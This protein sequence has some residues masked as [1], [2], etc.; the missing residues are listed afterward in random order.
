[1]RK[2]FL[3]LM[4]MALL[5]LAGWAQTQLSDGWE[6]VFDPTGPVTYTG[7]DKTPAVKLKKGDAFLTTGFN[8]AWSPAE[9]INAGSYT[10]T[11]TADNTNTYDDLATPTKKFW[12]LKANAEEKTATTLWGGGAYDGN[13]HALITTPPTFELNSN[14]DYAGITPL[15]SVDGT[16]WS[17]EIPTAKKPGTY[18]VYYKVEGN[19]NY[20]GIDKVE[21]GNV[22][23]TGTAL[24]ENTDYTAPTALSANINFDNEDH[25][26]LA[27]G[28][29]VAAGKGTMKYSLDGTSWG[30]TIPTGK[31][32]DNY[33]IYWKV[34]AAE[35]YY[36]VNNTKTA[37]IVAAK[38]AVTAATG[39]TGLVWDGEPK[40]LLSAEG[41][42]TLGATPKYQ[43]S[44]D[45]G[46][47]Y[48]EPLA[49]A[50]VTGTAAGTYKI[51]TLVPG[52]GNYLESYAMTGDD[53]T[54]VTVTIAGAAAFTA[55]P[56]A[57]NPTWNNGL[58]NLIVPGAN[59]VDGTVQYS[60][61]GGAYSADIPQGTDAKDYT[62]KYKV[63]D[64]NYADYDVEKTIE[65]VKINKKVMSIKVNNV[66]KTYDSGVTLFAGDDAALDGATEKFTFIGRIADGK[67]FSGITYAAIDAA[68]KNAGTH[69]DVLTI[70]T[71]TLTAISN[72]Y[73]YTIIPGTLTVEKKALTVTANTG[74]ST[75]YLTPR[76][77]SAEYTVA[78]YAGTEGAA[79]A[80]ATAPVLHSNAFG[81][82][83]EP[84]TYTLSFTKG[85]LKANGNYKMSAAGDGGYV[86]PD[87]ANFKV[88]PDASSKIV[89]TVL[90]KTYTYGDTE[91]YNLVEGTDYYVTGL[92]GDDVLTKA[93]T[94][95]RSD[96]D[97]KNVNTYELIATGAEVA[98]I[99]KYPGGFVYN[100]STVEIKQKEITVTVNPQTIVTGTDDEALA[101]LDQ[102]AWSVDGLEY[103]DTKASLQGTVVNMLTPAAGVAATPN[104]YDNGIEFTFDNANYKVAGP[105][106][107]K[108]IVLGAGSLILDCAKADNATKIAAQH[109]NIVNVSIDFTARNDRELP[110]GTAREWKANTWN[111]LVL[112]F[113]ITVAELSQKLGYAIVNVIDPSRTDISGTSSKFYGKLTMKGGNG[114]VDP[115]D[116]DKNDTKLAANKPFMVKTADA[117]TGVIDF[118]DK[119][120]IAPESAADL[121]V[122]ADA[123]GNV[124][125]TGTYAPK[126]VTGDDNAKI[127]FL[128]GNYDSW[129][130]IGAGKS[131]TWNVLPFEGFIDMTNVPAGAA[132]NMTFY[133]EELDGSTTAIRS[134]NV[135][136]LN[137]KIAAEGMYNLNGM[138]L[139][140]VPTQKGVYILNGK[141]VVIK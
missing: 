129:A 38:P 110:A 18:T 25:A 136:D 65:G 1:M 7:A 108:L 69:T 106:T 24:V 130:Y 60:V 47:T 121:S 107:G 109:G 22:I 23:I 94:F 133:F 138:K 5:P 112:P 98:D 104:T 118:G 33:T 92:I 30:T 99:T 10:V 51:K 50:A 27:D 119:K 100:N 46:A 116:A 73:D 31:D 78:G 17:E 81:D 126:E 141:K 15:Y 49:Y 72:N 102:D 80:F 36:D 34:E 40:N 39:A 79:D 84:G 68:N 62:V 53:P 54:V 85:V 45:N 114:Y 74:L 140:T 57:A 37:T 125:F 97:N 56:T 71:A 35:G 70:A 87:G 32:A 124:K 96:A 4:L 66:K 67:D 131:A 83:P 91:N 29:S 11:V 76:D 132:H 16:T 48:G 75:T 55:A 93:P 128:M 42:A 127:W 82:T 6:I 135:D 122:D 58:Q 134:V 59:T 9:I 14:A 61:D 120:I 90:P 19:D 113:D 26:L 77:I 64:P 103:E 123:A 86:I 8:V 3:L 63:V 52:A 89:I 21:V 43:I 2:H 111:T 105:V 139:N 117:I 44:T 95:S 13:S 20:N 88:N 101:Q 41:T 12:I 28:G 115:E 137:G